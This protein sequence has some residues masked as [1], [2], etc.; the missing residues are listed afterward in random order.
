MSE[1]SRVDRVAELIQRTLAELIQKEIKDPRL[2][3]FV[4]ISAVKVSRDLSYAKVYFTVFNG[5]PATA[6]A[7][8]NN[9]ASFLRAALAKSVTLRIAPQLNF[10]HD[11]SLEYGNRLSRLIDEVNNT[12]AEPESD[13]EI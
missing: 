1:F 5:D 12:D 6:Q 7:V 13:E 4:T 2:Q 8:L 9:A 10:V 11:V 3:G